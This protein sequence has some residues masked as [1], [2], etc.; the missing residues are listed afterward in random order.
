MVYFLKFLRE[1]GDYKMRYS[2]CPKCGGR[3]KVIDDPHKPICRE[4]NFIFYQNPIVG[5]AVIVIKGKKLLLGRRNNSY[6]GLW[7]IPCGYVE[8]DEDVYE[9][10]KREFLEET[11]L[12][13]DLKKV[14]TVHSNFHNPKQHTVGIWFLADVIGGQL[15]PSDDLDEVG[16]YSYAELPPLAFITDLKTIEQLREEGL[17]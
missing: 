1:K 7:C 14:Y 6:K 4:C 2:F 5:V 17:L 9:A 16:Y 13:V 3:L 10:A 11:G 8:W 15:S 12:K